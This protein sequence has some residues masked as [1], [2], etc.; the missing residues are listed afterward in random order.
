MKLMKNDIRNLFINKIKITLLA[1]LIM[2]LSISMVYIILTLGSAIKNDYIENAIAND[3][4]SHVSIHVLN[5]GEVALLEANTNIENLIKVNYH[6]TS[7]IKDSDDKLNLYS[8]NDHELEDIGYSFVEGRAVEGPREVVINEFFAKNS[9]YKLG[10]KIA[11]GNKSIEQNEYK[12]VGIVKPNR[13]DLSYEALGFIEHQESTRSMVYFNLNNFYSVDSFKTFISNPVNFSDKLVINYNDDLIQWENLFSASSIIYYAFIV[14]SSFVIVIT[15]LVN[16]YNLVKINITLN[17]KSIASYYE[18]GITKKALFNPIRNYIILIFLLSLIFSLLLSNLGYYIII[19]FFSTVFVSDKLVFTFDIASLIVMFTIALLITLIVIIKAKLYYNSYAITKNEFISSLPVNTEVKVTRFTK[20]KMVWVKKLYLKNKEH[21]R[22]VK[23]SLIFIMFIIPTI[24]IVN[25]SLKQLTKVNYS[26]TDNNV[27]VYNQTGSIDESLLASIITSDKYSAI[28]YI[29]ETGGPHSLNTSNQNQ[30]FLSKLVCGT[31]DIEI[32]ALDSESFNS[33][34]SELGLKYQKDVKQS[35]LVNMNEEERTTFN[36]G[37]IVKIILPNDELLDI[38][39]SHVTD[40]SPVNKMLFDG[41]VLFVNKDDYNV[42]DYKVVA[43]N[44][45]TEDEPAILNLVANHNVNVD[46]L[47]LPELLNINNSIFVVTVLSL[48]IVLFSAM[49]T[50][51]VS[52]IKLSYL[53]HIYKKTELNMFYE[54]GVDKK[55]FNKVIN[56]EIMLYT[57]KP[58]LLGLVLS[59]IT[60]FIYYTKNI[61][62]Y[63]ID[64]KLPYLSITIVLLLFISLYLLVKSSVYK[65]I[66]YYKDEDEDLLDL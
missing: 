22:L 35:I 1:T 37:H 53:I 62:V 28:K 31:N 60:L 9:N 27:L 63:H 21:Y 55:Q 44:I 32:I 65:N 12:I 5:E 41:E 48:Y 56:A 24:L 61:K 59:F 34:L 18:L 2:T 58:M 7:A 54:L 20:Q 15:A 19:N 23:I 17:I 3:S 4:S 45:T 16:F 29:F 47:S 43:Y 25:N 51:L 10:D 26:V 14:I 13:T 38:N 42:F 11:I 49:I 33:Y 52:L 36:V 64:Y 30:S 50:L 46:T 40:I 6:G 39:V 8:I 57:I 66:D